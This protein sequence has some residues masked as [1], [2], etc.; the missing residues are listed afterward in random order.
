V[1]MPAEV[2]SDQRMRSTERNGPTGRRATEVAGASLPVSVLGRA[3]LLVGAFGVDE[4][5]LGVSDL[6]RRTGL[7]KATVHRLATEMCTVRVLERT[8]EGAFRLGSWLFELGEMV[9]HHR[10]LAEAA[11]PIMEDLLEATHERIHLAVLDGI[12]V[13]Y[14]KILGGRSVSVASRE[15]GRLPA[16]ATGV[17]KVILAYSPEAAV[18]ARIDAGLPRL[19]ARTVATPGTLG[20]EL[21]RIRDHGLGMDREES[22]LGVSCVA[23]PVFGADGHVRAGLSI[24][25]PTRSVDPTKLGPAVRTAALTLSRV[26]RQSGL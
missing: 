17:G 6:S 20:R 21:A 19:T 5:F 14:V 3:A 12:D 15:G 26:L 1:T 22:H 23:A 4:P 13:V 24:T 8:D 10:S 11:Q 25:G 7:A 16:H 9:P 2:W 18:R